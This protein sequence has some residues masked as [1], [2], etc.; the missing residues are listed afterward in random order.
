MDVEL[1]EIN[2]RLKGHYRLEREL[3]R[4]GM[5]VVYLARDEMLDRPVAIKVLPRLAADEG[6][7]RER[8]LREA[9][10]AA[11]LSHPNVVPIY[12][13]DEVKGYAYFVMGF[14]DGESLAER[15]QTRGPLPLE[16]GVRY[17]R[18]VA[19]ALAYAH[20]RGVVHRDVKPE[21][22]MIERAT[23]RAIVTDFGIAHAQHQKRL[24]MDGH[25][26]GTAYY[27]S[28]EQV[29]GEVL[30]G[31]S[32][33][34]ALG[35][36]GFFALSGKLPFEGDSASAILVSHVTREPP[37]L[38]EVAPHVPASVAAVIDRC[39]S[40]RREDRYASGE[41]L[42]D[43][44][45]DAMTQVQGAG[46]AVAPGTSAPMVL[47]ETEAMAIWRRAAQLQA[48]AAQ[49]LEQR[50]RR[51][52]SLALSSG[53]TPMDGF[54]LR[55]V[56][57]AAIEAGIS[58]HF[59]A[60][61]IAELPKEAEESTQTLAGWQ[62]RA[63]ARW[64]GST[65]QSLSVSRVIRATPRRT[66]QAMGRVLSAPPL[67]LVFQTHVGAH[68]LDGGV[69][70]YDLPQWQESAYHWVYT[71]WGVFAKTVRV[72]MRPLPHDSR[73]TEVTLHIDLRRGL[74]LNL[75]SSAGLTGAMS[76]GAGGAAA[77]IAVKALAMVG[78]A[79]A[80]PILG[81][82]AAVGALG[83]FG[84]A[85]G[86][87]YAI[88]KVREELDNALRFIEND[89]RSEELFGAPVQSATGARRAPAPGAMPYIG[90]G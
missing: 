74:K 23:A 6:E 59:V 66:L 45:G 53:A 13:A 28:P 42:A 84:F 39:L 27:M 46:A 80:L 32:D 90:T 22:I 61:A 14:I 65:E 76:V 64:F 70:V 78:A 9:R 11:Q 49:R 16:E 86:Y 89:V 87:R 10:T 58:Q 85:A 68:P 56:E 79:I 3:G 52:E 17:L 82:V 31:R 73:A 54:K 38:R 20:A 33:L 81:G 51:S 15:V 36:V 47:K 4:G 63:A 75:Y 12:R 77:G 55:E 69:L 2:E 5:G 44:L 7:Q 34:Y 43:A 40:K 71:R 88:R 60:L 21:N 57:A 83:T 26:L 35:V 48:E 41:E 29:N 50:A 1:S 25:V 62:E 67:N 30:D 72:A 18:E 37:S 19:W 24:T 8:F